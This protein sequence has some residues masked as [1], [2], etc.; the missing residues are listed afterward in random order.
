MR[1]RD[2]KRLRLGR[3]H[4]FGAIKTGFSP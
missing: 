3:E 1:S 2:P 4:H